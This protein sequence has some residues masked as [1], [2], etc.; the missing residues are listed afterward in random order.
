MEDY[1]IVNGC[2]TSFVLHECRDSL[3][4]RVMVPV[5]LIA[6]QDDGVKNAIIKAT[7]RQTLVTREQLLPIAI[8]NG[9][10]SFPAPEI[11]W[12]SEIAPIRVN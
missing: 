7:N 9:G 1:Q 3:N 11:P 4:E 8:E 6:T 10:I 2:Q 12:R 5:R